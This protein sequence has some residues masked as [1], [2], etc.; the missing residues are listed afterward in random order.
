M[1]KTLFDDWSNDRDSGVSRTPVFP[2]P[3]RPVARAAMVADVLEA[4]SGGPP[5]S[6]LFQSHVRRHKASSC[7]RMCWPHLRDRPQDSR[8]PRCQGAGP[9][10]ES[11]DL[12]R[13]WESRCSLSTFS[14]RTCRSRSHVWNPT[15]TL[16]LSALKR[17]ILSTF[18]TPEPL[19]VHCRLPCPF[20][21]SPCGHTSH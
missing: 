5:R 4:R 3:Q 8:S 11:G 6:A 7:E 13:I 19:T 1:A 15:E 20:A 10:R 18:S 2:Q 21:S 16:V 14:S 12:P 17:P 9:N